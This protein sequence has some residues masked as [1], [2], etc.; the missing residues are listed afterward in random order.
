MAFEAAPVDPRLEAR[1]LALGF[2]RAASGSDARVLLPYLAPLVTRAG[3]DGEDEDVPDAVLAGPWPT[4]C[5]RASRPS[6]RAGSNC[7]ARPMA[8]SRRRSC[9]RTLLHGAA[10]RPR[11]RGLQRVEGWRIEHPRASFM[12]MHTGLG[13]VDPSETALLDELGYDGVGCGL[14]D[15]AAL[16]APWNPSASTS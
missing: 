7:A 3:A 11:R 14:G 8:T 10:A 2:A 9:S 5:E 13:R 6:P 4:R 12:A 15:A 1:E 16:Q